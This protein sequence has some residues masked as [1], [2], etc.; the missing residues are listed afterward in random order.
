MHFSLLGPLSVRDDRG[1]VELRGGLRRTLLAALLLHAGTPVSVDRLTE[2]LWGQKATD[3][4]PARLHNQV[5]RLRQALADGGERIRA[6]PPGYLIHV[7]PG[8]LDLHVFTEEHAAGR[9]ELADKEWAEAARRFAAALELW[10]GRPLAD[11]SAL[12]D[13]PRIRELEETHLQTLQGRI[14]AEL[15]LS[16]HHELLGKLR[17]LTEEHPRHEAFRGQLML[18]LYRAGRH[19]DA[20]AAYD[21]YQDSLA[22]ELGLEPS[23]ELRE[24]REAI[25]RQDPAL[26]PPRRPNAPRQ[27]PADTRTFTGRSA[28]L[29]ELVAAAGEA[30]GALVISA[31]DGMAGIGKTALAVHTA[32]RIADR[33]PDGQ[34]FIDLR[35]DT[36]GLD[37]LS[38]DDA[39]AYLLRALGVAPRSIP[40]DTRAR[41]TLYRTKLTDSRTLIVLDNAANAGQVE[42]LLPG[43]PGCL[44]LITSRHRLIDL[45]GARS[46]TLDILGED[47]AVALLGK[48]AGVENAP[49]DS[50]AVRELAALCGYVP[51]ALRIVAARL[52]HQRDLTVDVL[53]AQMRDEGGRLAQLSDGDR[54]LTSV[55]DAAF[56]SLPEAERNLLRTLGVLPG[57]DVDAYAAANLLGADLRAAQHLLDSL[58]DRNLL[59]QQTTGRYRLHD[60]IRAY[61][62]SLPDA[63]GDAAHG[64]RHRLLDYYENTAWTADVHMTRVTRAGRRSAGEVSGPAPELPDTV[65]ALAWIRTEQANLLA[66]IADAATPP[67][68]RI[69]LTAALA[70][71]LLHDGPWQ[72]AA[73]LHEAAARA[74]AELGERR[75][76]AEALWDLG[77]AEALLLTGGGAYAI[78][79][80][81]QAL[82]IFRE[83][84]DRL[85]EA[86][87]LHSI[88]SVDYSVGDA[89]SALVPQ[90][91][92]T[93]IF[94]EIGDRLG[95]AR[96]L[97]QEA[98]LNEIL[99]EA[100]AAH[101]LDLAALAAFREV[102]NRRG[103]LLVVHSL[104]RQDLAAGDLRSA[105]AYLEQALTMCREF[106]QRQ[107]EAATLLDLGRVHTVTGEYA[108]AAELMDVAIE[109]FRDLG[110]VRGVALGNW[111]LGRVRLE[112]GELGAAIGLLE[113]AGKLYA[114]YRNRHGEVNALRDLGI[115]RY[116]AGDHSGALALEQALEAFREEV[117]DAQG[118]AETLVYLGEVAAEQN[119]PDRARDFYRKAVPLAR[120]ASSLIDE[121]RALD[122]IARCH[123]RLGEPEAAL[124][125]LREAVA[126]YRRMGLAG[127][128]EAEERLVALGGAG[129]LP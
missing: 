98:K 55:F 125:S 28:E 91:E 63:D 54:D 68:L 8:E 110:F 49:A 13:D 14:E 120:Q 84:G 33:F 52:R 58:L 108:K 26:S 9:R 126:M 27:L 117:Q 73:A 80:L 6:V 66:A 106:G 20:A 65:H 115:A 10:R 47:E 81:E 114:S 72:Q 59:L 31:L 129:V 39:L 87:T 50:P 77:R 122:G 82:A 60:L 85:G 22:D 97:H 7:E 102:G 2:C 4:D 96:S 99:G 40:S 19:A 71:Q 32:H 11:I 90:R 118:E 62:R 37:P 113:E 43:A 3:A 48:V 38:A 18:A 128:A 17:A 5:L 101:R 123:E 24:L 56:A 67:A 36:R 74:A 93:A 100:L 86:N 103:E 119:A 69:S 46:L 95:E 1:P 45:D 92:A 121:A 70:S 112:E 94:R 25:V 124:E 105:A 116:R 12:A 34:L 127:L 23:T 89:A 104:G 44:V 41:T 107:N 111:R 30:S 51:L 15:N 76:E 64:A 88:C 79:L 61:A 57:P 78:S 21:T 16:R 75:G 29:A 35:G 42:P 109:A 53:V 83:I